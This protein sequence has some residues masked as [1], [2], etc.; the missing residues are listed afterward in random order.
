MLVALRHRRCQKSIIIALIIKKSRYLSA[1]NK[2]SCLRHMSMMFEQFAKN[3]RRVCKS[4]I[5]IF[6]A[7]YI[8]ELCII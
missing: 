3:V 6:C 2:F 7:F 8:A 5:I 4:V 1:H